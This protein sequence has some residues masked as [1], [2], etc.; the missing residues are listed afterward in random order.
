MNESQVHY[1]KRKNPYHNAAIYRT[2]RKRQN[3]RDG[4]QGLQVGGGR[5]YKGAHQGILGDDETVGV[6][7]YVTVH[8]SKL[9]E[10]YTKRSTLSD[11]LG[12][13]F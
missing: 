3:Y 11:P 4:F 9:M 6:D 7:S 13:L 12:W 2:F 1:A 10:D 8:L 5:D